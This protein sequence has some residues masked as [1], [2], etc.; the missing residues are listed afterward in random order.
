MTD[1]IKK[2]RCVAYN[3]KTINFRWFIQLF[4]K[5][6]NFKNCKDITLSLNLCLWD[7]VSISVVAFRNLGE[8]EKR[9][10][11]GNRFKRTEFL[12]L[13]PFDIREC[14]VGAR[15]DFSNKGV[16]VQVC[17]HGA[18]GTKKERYGKFIFRVTRTSGGSH[19][20]PE[21]MMRVHFS[22]NKYNIDEYVDCAKRNSIDICRRR[23]SH[24]VDPV[25]DSIEF[26]TC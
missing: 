2:D 24:L 12:R 5:T 1:L 26:R 16:H 10:G 7:D 21:E 22:R 13:A 9:E 19:I 14:F 23:R 8:E 25:S 20:Y 4:K 18:A 6:I 3:R 17:S 15:G 11:K